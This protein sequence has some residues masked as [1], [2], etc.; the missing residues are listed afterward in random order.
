M[1]PRSKRVKNAVQE[2]TA[3]SASPV[4]AQSALVAGKALCLPSVRRPP[5][6]AAMLK[7]ARATG[8]GSTFSCY[9]HRRR[10]HRKL[11]GEVHRPCPFIIGLAG[12][13][14]EGMLRR[15]R[16]VRHDKVKRSRFL[17][18]DSL[19]GAHHFQILEQ[20]IAAIAAC[21]HQGRL[22]NAPCLWPIS[23]K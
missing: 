6:A 8:A 16:S 12:S 5:S 1:P 7:A 4:G 2:V 14:R 11:C 21:F 18:A 3:H 15:G 17:S 22:A 13:L 10:K 23:A 20:N 19:H 9:P